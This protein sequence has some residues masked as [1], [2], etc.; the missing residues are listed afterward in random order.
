MVV[1]FCSNHSYRNL[2][3]SH[4]RSSTNCW[5]TTYLCVNNVIRSAALRQLCSLYAADTLCCRPTRSLNLPSSGFLQ[6]GEVRESPKN[7]RVRESQSTRVQKLTKMQIKNLNYCT[8]TAYNGSEFFLLASL[9]EYFY[10]HFAFVS[11]VIASDWKLR[12][13][14]HVNRLVGENDSFCP[15]KSRKSQGKW[16]MNSAE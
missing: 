12:L 10:V 11:S 6:S 7:Q 5:L 8:Q 15:R 16:K 13:L 1:A 3:H 4:G 9:A 14:F 2:Q